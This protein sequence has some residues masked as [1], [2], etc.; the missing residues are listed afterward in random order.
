MLGLSDLRSYQA[1]TVKRIV[2]NYRFGYFMD[3]G[4]GKTVS[5]LTA[6]DILKY[7]ELAIDKALIVGPKRVIESVWLQETRKWSH[8]QHLRVSIITGTPK[9]REK[10]LKVEADIY[11]ISCD[12][13]AWL[14]AFFGSISLPFDMLA[15]DESSKFKNPKSGRFR[16]LRMVLATFD[17]VNILTGTPTPN[18]LIDLWAQIYLLDQGKR[19][20]KTP[21]SYKDEF[22]RPNK[23]NGHIVYSYKLRNGAEQRIYDAISD[24]CVSMKAEDYIELPER[25]DNLIEIQM[26]EALQKKYREFEKERVLELFDNDQEISAVTAA[27][28]CNK[29]LQFANGAVYDQDKAYHEVHRLKLEA[30]EEI[31]ESAQ[32]SPVLVAYTYKSDCDRIQKYFSSYKPRRLEKDQDIVD[33]NAGLIPIALIHPQGAGHGLNLQDG[34]HTLAWFGHT[35][36]SELKQQTDAR[37]Y[38]QGQKFPSIIHRIVVVGTM[39]EDVIAAQDRK[40]EK[41]NHLL[42]AVKARVR[43]FVKQKSPE[44]SGRRA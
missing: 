1:L 42:D 19:L 21:T 26:P 40:I 29:L 11:L 44:R 2:D 5:T 35:W 6:I 9:Q 32:G 41:Q 24:I 43:Q 31:I 16:A 28:L 4:L 12:N 15:I 10:A 17:Y 22:F 37:I 27:T 7:E 20:G 36:S 23:R 34:G 8:L 18:G 25:I 14:C 38:R 33:W 3:M 39:D 13:V 30:L